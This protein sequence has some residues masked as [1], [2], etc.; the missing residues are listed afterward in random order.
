MTDKSW[1]KA[2]RTVAH[3]L[4]GTRNPLPGRSGGHTSGD[5]IHPALYVEV[6]QRA[7]FAVLSTMRDTEEKA[8]KENKIPVLVLHEKGKKKRYYVVPESYIVKIL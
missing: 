4:G 3:K 1:K 2:E 6:K 7:R 8:K 5:V